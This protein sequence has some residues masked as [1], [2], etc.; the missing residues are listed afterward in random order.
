[1]ILQEK[2]LREYL[3]GTNFTADEFRCRCCGVVKM[4]KSFIDKILKLREL[5]KEPMYINSGYRC[6]NHPDEI[7]KKKP[8]AGFHVK[9]EGVDI[10]VSTRKYRAKLIRLAH[11]CSITGIGVANNFLHLDNRSWDALYCYPKTK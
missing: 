6:Q 9:S 1:M 11:A 8:W 5:M 2:E 4:Q 10:R 3:E 7:S